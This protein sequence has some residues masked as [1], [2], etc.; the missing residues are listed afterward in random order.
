LVL[1]SLMLTLSRR[2]AR[3]AGLLVVT[4][5][6]SGT[7]SSPVGTLAALHAR[8][9]EGELDAS[10]A[11]LTERRRYR[12]D[13]RY[14][15]ATATV[16]FYRSLVGPEGARVT[17]MI[18]DGQSRSGSTLEPPQA[19][20]E[21][22]RL[23]LELG[24]PSPLRELGSPLFVSE[25]IELV[26]PTGGTL[27]MSV[28]T[29][30]PLG[31]HGTL[32]G[33]AM[34]V[35]WNRHPVDAVGIDVNART[36]APLRS[37]YSPYHELSVVRD[38]IYAARAKYAG[39]NVCTG[40]DLT[41]LLSSGEGLV[42]LDVLPFRYGNDEGGYFL[43]LLTPDPAPPAE[44]VMSRD[45]VLV[46]DTSGSM[47]GVKIAEAKE[48]LS[49][50]LGGLRTEDSFAVVTFSD[51]VRSFQA[52]AVK[53]QADNIAAALA[54]V[55]G[56]EAKGSTNLYD[57]LRAGFSAL[58]HETGHPRYVV[59]L[60]DG[61]P[62]TGEVR[63]DAIAAMAQASNEI[64]ARVFSFGIGDD[65][66]TVLLDRLA[67]QSS[68][69]AFYIRSGQ[70]VS[71]AVQTFFQKVAD[72]IL[73]D[74]ALDF[75]S[76][77]VSQL[78]PD[79]VDDLFAGR[80]VTLFG[81]Y[82]NPGRTNLTLSGFRSGQPWSTVFGVTLPEYEIDSGYV[83]RVWALRR[84]GRLLA[85]IKQGNANPELVTE[86][87]AVAKRFGVATEFTYFAVDAQGNANMTYSPVPVADVGAIAVD[88]STALNGYGKGNAVGIVADATVRYFAD[89]SLP[90]QESYLTDTKVSGEDFV[91]L[92]F[93]S[94][95][96]FAF[97]GAEAPFGAAGLL[98]TA[99]NAKF[100]LL[101]RSFR[102]TDPAWAAANAKDPP[103]E[104]AAIPEPK[105]IPTGAASEAVVIDAAAG[106]AIEGNNPTGASPPIGMHAGGGCTVRASSSGASHAEWGLAVCA[107]LLLRRR[108][109]VSS[110]GRT[111]E[112]GRQSGLVPVSQ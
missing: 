105:W 18:I 33:I 79:V 71:D 32:Q 64:G 99:S 72:P 9:V 91:D 5:G 87:L 7:A 100:E 59:L 89:R 83:P 44:N 98:S 77:G 19:D 65:V 101:G 90:I 95:L 27:E 2:D 1:L 22:R 53:A 76:L 17:S 38:G 93:G 94:D 14:F 69:D 50:V 103:P 68:G 62:T 16:T 107:A 78:Y 73:S 51:V 20:A 96:Y 47:S 11:R 23:A 26:V 108:I 52:S 97:A 112:H 55:D 49:G 30:T 82:A 80:T 36:E 46:L 56:L 48:A 31:T 111:P 74:P 6:A 60:T 12:F 4:G 81:R 15:G 8:E 58:P 63:T 39:H 42:K 24:D 84:V 45:I 21:R 43:A 3:A 10:V 75:G 13:S 92:S 67:Q 86:A 29:S 54:F 37:L 110:S 70:S 28:A 41:I 40:L 85:A 109:R 25:P 106:P 61:V 57:A 66:N 34:P 35:D 88:T 104:A 102:I